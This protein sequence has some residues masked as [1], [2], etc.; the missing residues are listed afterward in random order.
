M[1]GYGEIALGY[2]VS[3]STVYP[4]IRYTGR[5][6][7]APFGVMSYPE[8][9]II[10]GSGSQLYGPRGRWGDYTDM[11]VDPVDAQTFWYTNE[12]L[13][14]TRT[15]PWRTRIAAFQFQLDTIPPA[16]ITDLQAINSFSNS[17][18]LT[19]TATGDDSTAGRD[20]QYDT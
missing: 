12:Y 5:A 19:W 6:P 2:L 3:S 1:N 13:P 8:T 9:E 4:S 17:I 20:S 14:Y 10:A 18:E 15:A 7:N 16:P 11:T